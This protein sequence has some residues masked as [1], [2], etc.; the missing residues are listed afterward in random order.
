MRYLLFLLLFADVSFGQSVIKLDKVPER[1][2]LVVGIVV[3]QMRWDYLY[4]YYDRYAANGGFKRLLNQGISCEN[5]FINYT[6]TITACGHTCIFTGSVPAIHG[7]T[8]NDWWDNNLNREV[9]CTEDKTVTEVGGS[10]DAGRMSPG[11]L[12]VTTICDELKLATNFRSKVIGVAIKDRGSILPAGHSANAA[13]WYEGSTGNFITSSY[14]MNDLPQWVKDFNAKKIPDNYFNKGW[15][16]LY[17]AN[18]YIQSTVDEKSY[19]GTPL[20]VEQKG[21]PYK[22]DQFTGKRYGVLSSTPY[23]NSLT[24]DMALAAITNEQL[25][26]DSITDFLT[27]SFSSTDY[28]GHAFGPNSVEVEDTYLRLDKDLGEFFRFLDEKIEKDKYLVFLS[29]DHGVSHAPGFAKENK[30]PGGA[31]SFLT[32]EKEL[33]DILRQQFGS[34]KIFLSASNYQIT[35]NHQLIDSLKADEALVKKAIIGYFERQEGVAQVFETSKIMTVPINSEV[36]NMLANG[37]YPSRSGDIQVILKPG[38]MEGGSAG[39]THG[40]W[41]PYDAHIPMLWY[42]WNL[43]PAKITRKVHMTDI[44]PTLASLLKIQAPSGSVGEVITEIKRK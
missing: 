44:A 13:Y 15:N 19:E 10:G 28:V 4:R 18:T 3:D 2:R 6:P 30:L 21:F 12:L 26:K 36:R 42:G 37:F 40:S 23:G 32:V 9:Y 17:P 16:T 25:G 35:L 31:M 20:G 1:P 7:I 39:T 34:E 29:A 11:N 14:Y 41:N 22:L 8:G 24:K 5:T 38:W 33:K 43:Q 27:I